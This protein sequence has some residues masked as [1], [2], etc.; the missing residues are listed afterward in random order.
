MIRYK[1]LTDFCY[2]CNGYSY[3]VQERKCEQCSK[4][5]RV[6]FGCIQQL[7]LMETF[8]NCGECKKAIERNSKLTE[9][10]IN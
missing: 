2:I 5:K 3:S 4:R 10:G 1:S 8:G 7:A 6:C 9:I